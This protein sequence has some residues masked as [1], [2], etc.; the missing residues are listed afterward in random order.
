MEHLLSREKSPASL[1]GDTVVLLSYH[2]LTA[3]EPNPKL[4]WDFLF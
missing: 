3:K 2:L 1:A 4:I